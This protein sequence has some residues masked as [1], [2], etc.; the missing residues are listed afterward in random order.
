[1]LTPSS[2][3]LLLH[4]AHQAPS[5]DNSQPWRLE[6]HNQILSVA[7]DTARVS[8]KT[9]PA[10][11]PATLLA[12]GAVLENISQAA[13]W[14]VTWQIP[15]TLDPEQPIYFRALIGQTNEESKVSI[16]TLPLFK[17]HTNRFPYCSQTL[18]EALINVI[19][20]LT[21]GSARVVIID[22][23]SVIRQIAR[24]VLLA[25]EIRFRTREVHEWL[26]KSLRFDD[27]LSAA[28]DGLD[29]KTLALPPGGRTILRLISVWHRMEI[30]NMFGAFKALSII[31]S[32]PVRQAPALIAILSPSGFQD[33]IEAGQLMER[34]WIDL[35]GQGVAVH[36]YYVVADQLHRRISGVIPPDLRKQAD[37][38]F[39]GTRQILQF[40]QG[41]TLQ[42]LLRIG[43][44]KKTPT[45]SRRL[46]LEA[47][48]SQ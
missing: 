21:V 42:M 19:K 37:A 26:A 38:V 44:P 20:N 1:M 5:A 18:P 47:V 24:L 30:L 27:S 22:Q 40:E 6:W 29:V 7:Y 4:A 16:D 48:C 33:I 46:P 43:Y 28:D 12:M 36:P 32:N 41:E 2:L 31:D 11:S 17:R 10:D 9:F 23:P 34:I 15:A 13:E 45:L 35:N 14:P 25:S 39:E 3:K 8:N